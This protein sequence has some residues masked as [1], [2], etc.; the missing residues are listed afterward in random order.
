MGNIY[1]G[2]D[3]GTD[4]IK[5][6]VVEKIRNKFNL[7]ASTSTPSSYINNGEIS[8]TKGCVN[9]LKGA[10]SE[11]EDMLGLKID[12]AICALNPVN[13]KMDIVEG[14]VK[15]DD[16]SSITG[17]DI[18]N[19]LN[20]AIDKVDLE[21]AE[22]VTATPINFL[23]DDNKRVSDPKGLKGEELSS[24]I[25]VSSI[26]KKAMYRVLEVLK[27]AGVDTVDVCFKSTGDY[28]IV[29]NSEYDKLVGAIINIGEESTNVSVFNK[30][31][32]IKNS[33]VNMG[34]KHVD[35]DISYIFNCELE[36][37]RDLKENFALCFA[38]DAD[39]NESVT[40]KNK[41]DEDKEVKQV[42]I[43][44]IVEARVR[45]IL[46]LAGEE[47]KNLTNRKISYIIVTGGLSEIDGMDHLVD[48]YF[49]G[50]GKVA[51]IYVMGIR[52]NKYSSVLGSC[53]YFDDKLNLRGKTYNMVNESEFD[54]LVSIDSEMSNNNNFVNRVF[55]HFFD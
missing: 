54:N 5:I 28:Y 34:S 22:L 37:S 55:G 31:I 8:N 52:H 16:P 7:L 4:S 23:I 29:K 40:I 45:E 15:V 41:D 9:A 14:S 48:V 49:E 33:I 11:I 50:I 30:G 46:K 44:K 35:R 10:L 25:V 3:L 24:K 42:A 38:E 6:V 51:Q 39:E 19:L 47:I 26:D 13:L 27:M 1:T 36:T 53:I 43:S 32:Q 2:I 20:D 18:S 21:D 17:V 12:K